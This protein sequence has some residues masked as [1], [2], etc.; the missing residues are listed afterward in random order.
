M[1]RFGQSTTHCVT[2]VL[3]STSSGFGVSIPRNRTRILTFSEERGFVKNR[4]LEGEPCAKSF[5]LLREHKQTRGLRIL[6]FAR[7]G[8][9]VEKQTVMFMKDQRTLL[10][11]M[12]L[13]LGPMRSP[14]NDAYFI[15]TSGCCVTL[16]FV[17]SCTRV[18]TGCPWAIFHQVPDK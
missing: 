4:H 18:S 12:W 7:V 9:R 13:C 6:Y 11:P 2:F 5:R 10:W 15:N 17:T 16:A 3:T 1:Q 8:W 14:N